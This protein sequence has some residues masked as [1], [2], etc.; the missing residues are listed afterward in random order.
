[1]P[2]YGLIHLPEGHDSFYF[3]PPS[4]ESK[5]YIFLC[6]LCASNDPERSRREMGGEIDYPK[7]G[8]TSLFYHGDVWSTSC[9]V[10]GWP[11]IAWSIFLRNCPW[12]SGNMPLEE[13]ILFP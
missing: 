6:G 11:A 13:T 3:R 8:A 12:D 5:I 2:G 9:F 1:M 10:T 7:S 4:G